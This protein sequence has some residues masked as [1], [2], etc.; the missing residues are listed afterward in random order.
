MKRT[1][2]RWTLREP[3]AALA[4]ELERAL[5]VRPLLA[6]LLVNRGWH[7]PAVAARTIDASLSKSLRS[8]M[9]FADM[10]RAAGRLLRA[11]RQGERIAIYGDYDVDGISASTELLLF[12]REL[13]CEPLLHIP[14]RMTDG[15]GLRLGA[16]RS[17]GERGARLIV[18]ADCGAAAH[19]EIAEAARLGLEM[20]ICDHHQ[21]PETRPPALAV[22]NPAVADCGFPFSGLCAAG[23]VFYLLLG[24]RMML[25][26]TGGP[27]PDLRRYLDLA[28]LGTVADL[29]PLVEENRI[30]VKYGIHEIAR[31]PRPG[32]RALLE[33]GDVS[34]PTVDA[35]GFRLGPR[36]NASGR[37]ADA[38]RA[39]ELLASREPQTARRLAAEMDV[40]NRERRGIEDA[41]LEE[42]ERMVAALPNASRRRSFVLASEGWHPGVVGVVAARLVERHF[43]P[44][45]LLAIEGHL[46]RGSARGI[47]SVHLFEALRE[48]AD[49]LERFGGHRLAAG[50]TIRADRIHSLAERLEASV[51]SRTTDASFVPE[52]RIDARLELDAVSAQTLEDI[53]KLEPYGQGNPRPLFL[54]ERLEVTS[55]RV[56]G[57]RHLK[58]CVRQDGSRKIFDAIAFRRGEECPAPGTR[59]DLVFTP[60]V[61]TWQGFERLQ[62]MIRDLRESAAVSR[63]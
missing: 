13:G 40:Y 21:N 38:T 32:V 49:L 42:A 55:S 9:L 43:R 50:L 59:V 3:D 47:P 60:E 2:Q 62:I 52:L 61:S 30:L 57:E 18:T 36:L 19:T 31:N 22:L 54:A 25:R 17:L 23:V 29:V 20:I 28:A 8:P 15:Y 35:I 51:D 10:G 63:V 33:V 41:T 44:V 27:V 4:S 58:L 12:L 46:A 34:E 26:E 5:G 6:R 11:I 56:V 45:V 39:V 37:L 7:D 53:A 16:L 24:T 14:N 1:A 48:S